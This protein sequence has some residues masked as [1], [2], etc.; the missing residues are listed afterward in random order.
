MNSRKLKYKI[1]Y[2]QALQ[3]R[4]SFVLGYYNKKFIPEK[5]IQYGGSLVLSAFMIVTT[6]FIVSQMINPNLEHDDDTKSFLDAQKDV[7]SKLN[8]PEI[9]L[10]NQLNLQLEKGFSPQQIIID[11]DSDK[12]KQLILIFD[13]LNDAI[14]NKHFC[15]KDDTFKNILN[16][17]YK[18]A[19]RK[20]DHRDIIT[21]EQLCNEL[22]DSS[23]E[24]INNYVK[25]LDNYSHH[26]IYNSYT[27]H[28]KE[29]FNS[30]KNLIMLNLNKRNIVRSF[31]LNE[32]S[33]QYGEY[34]ET[35]KMENSLKI[36]LDENPEDRAFLINLRKL[37]D[38]FMQNQ[39]L[40][41]DEKNELRKSISELINCRDTLLKFLNKNIANQPESIRMI[42]HQISLLNAVLKT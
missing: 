14:Y 8:Q 26:E 19:K 18:V 15:T 37:M 4:A 11:L 28:Q 16:V 40:T 39:P 7:V 1:K 24:F 13:Q 41:L 32:A 23:V 5:H 38:K 42:T 9:D 17:M 21:E 20:K 10:I 36:Y 35:T 29:V 34:A 31:I 22:S 2:Y 12:T 6:F 3:D 30:I 25:L 33:K 27:P